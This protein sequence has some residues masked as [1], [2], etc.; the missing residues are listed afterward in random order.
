M[1]AIAEKHDCPIAVTYWLKANHTQEEQPWYREFGGGKGFEFYPSVS[2]RL[3][4][5]YKRPKIV[6]AT[7]TKHRFG[8]EGKSCY[9]AIDCMGIRDLSDEEKGII[10]KIE[11]KGGY[12]RE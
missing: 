6:R 4:E 12:E 11:R 9:F 3:E 1:K 2:V 10:E 8:E 7:V 5:V